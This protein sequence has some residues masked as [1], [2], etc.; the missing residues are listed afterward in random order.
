MT[1]AFPLT[2]VISF[3]LLLASVSAAC[4]TS[5]PPTLSEDTV[6]SLA[7]A[8][9]NRVLAANP[10]LPLYYGI[11]VD[12]HDGYRDNSPEAQRVWEAFEDSL[13]PLVRQIDP[14]DLVGTSSWITHG[15]LVEELEASIGKRICREELWN[16]NHMGGWHGGLNRIA[17]LQPIGT[18]NL[19]TQAIARFS[20][21]PRF[22]DQ[23]IL[24]LRS[25]LDLGY[26]APKTAVALVIKQIEGML[27]LGVDD[28]PLLSPAIRDS[29]E[30]FSELFR[31]LIEEEINPALNRYKTFLANEYHSQAR[32]ELGVSSLPDGIECYHAS[33]RG[34]TT[35]SRTA[36]QVYDLGSETVARY[37]ADV[38][39]IGSGLYGV[40]QFDEILN[41]VKTDESNRFESRDEYFEF[42]K[43][44]VVRAE[45][46]MAS[47]F[48]TVPADT[49]IVEPHPA[50]LDGTGVS[51]RYERGSGE[52][53]AT[54]RINTYDLDAATR[55]SAERLAV[56]EAYPGHHLQ[57]AIAKK[58]DG[59]HRLHNI[60]GYSGF[61]EGWARYAEALG[62]EMGLYA[63]ETTRI[64]RRAW[65]ARGMVV[66]PGLHV[67]GWTRDEAVAF[68]MESGGYSD[69]SANHMVDRISVLP[70]QLTSY[71]S[72][73]LEIFALRREA[74]TKLGDAFD[75]RTF[76]DKILQNGA[77]PLAMLRAN[78]ETWISE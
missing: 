47:W 31:K 44:F 66:D 63:Y 17:A 10:V 64:S 13:L 12:R 65:P 3:A 58:L 37:K 76:H 78:I 15:V 23:E 77:V 67:F 55:G 36:Q 22:I 43:D 11:D 34:Y 6:L 29:S 49:V 19:R 46:T 41:A 56:H 71:D 59:L 61:S 14:D 8:Y 52:S 68:I 9:Y 60:T 24:N 73:G 53:P 25:G 20:E 69:E 2:R 28:S 16:V 51:S 38:I 54:F 26:S 40:D 57:I 1:Q 5:D 72:G 27:E 33:L 62:E 4:D 42:C 30:V 50:Y 39:E 18:E 35:L 48:D 75:I 45:P 32:A 21:L 7:D 74:E 70:G